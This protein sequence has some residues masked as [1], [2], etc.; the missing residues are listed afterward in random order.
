QD[1][2][3]PMPRL[4]LYDPPQ[5]SED[6]PDQARR[7]ASVALIG[8]DHL[9]A[10]H[11]PLHPVEDARGVLAVVAS[12]LVDEHSEHEAER[13]GDDVALAALDE[14][15]PVEAALTALYRRLHRLAVDDRRRRRG[16]ATGTLAR[17]AAQPL[18]DGPDEAA[19]A[20]PLEVVV[21]GGPGRERLREH[22]PL[23]PGL[24]EVEHGVEDEAEV[25]LA[26]ALGIEQRSDSFPLSVRQVGAKAPPCRAGHGFGRLV[27]GNSRDAG[28][29]SKVKTRTASNNFKT[30]RRSRE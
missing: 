18:V 8:E 4:P 27:R 5:P 7:C 19:V 6:A 25:V 9:Q 16:V 11:A 28:G 24:G 10:W 26:S 21:D 20:P 3:P 22:P 30:S 13:V 1:R 12:G 14:L 17:E 15:P 29:R 2:E 23:A